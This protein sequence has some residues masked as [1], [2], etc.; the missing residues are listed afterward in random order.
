MSKSS[1]DEIGADLFP[2]APPSLAVRV[3]LGLRRF[4]QK[5]TDSLAPVE[6]ALFERSVG[7]AQ[8]KLFGAAASL[9]LADLLVA[10]PLD[11]ADLAR[12]TNTDP[13]TLHRV[14]RAL[15]V[16]GL[17]RLRSDGRFENN[18]LSRGFL[19]GRRTRSRQWAEY[20]SS[21][22]NVAAWNDL[23]NTLRTGGNGF[24]HVHGMSVWDW[25][26]A[27]PDER[28]AFAQA[29]MG[30]TTSNAPVI[31]SRYPFAELRRVCDVGGG[32][33]TLLSEILLRHPHLE[34][35]LCDSAGVLESARELLARRGVL[36]RTELVPGSFFDSVPLG[37][38]A[39][40]MKNILHDWD[41]ARCRHILGVTRRSMQPGQRLILCEAIVEHD[42]QDLGALADVQ[43]MMVCSDGRER[44]RA[45]FS[46]LLASTGFRLGRVF[47]YPTVSVLEGIAV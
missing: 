44:S 16:L 40:I 21:V 39:Y 34:G 25:F 36:D 13:D 37:C 24:E 31:A 29:M 47:P 3:V 7:L 30:I 1:D 23:H 45:E 46:S 28:E 43:M 11:A 38:D 41:D 8:T 15:T 42:T 20:F 32:R 2:N 18:R 35:V 26:D 33:G 14:L 27:H 6:L 9:G 17:F 4:L 19:S 5:L 12:H 10:G 22:S